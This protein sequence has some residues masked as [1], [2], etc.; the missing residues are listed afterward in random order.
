MPPDLANHKASGRD[1]GGFF[2]HPKSEEDREDGPSSCC[3]R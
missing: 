1:A 2:I 3:Q